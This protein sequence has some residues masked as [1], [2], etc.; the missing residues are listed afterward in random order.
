[1][2]EY[3]PGVCN[4]GKNE[5]KKRYALAVVAFIISALV[6]YSV[7]L[8]NWPRLTLFISFIPLVMCFEGFYQGYFKFC[9][10]FAAAGKYDFTGSGNSKNKV[11]D[12]ESHKKDL[13]KAKQIHLYSIITAAIISIIIYLV[14]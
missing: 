9:A 11:A 5:I 1:M 13:R 8:L 10:G 3:K 7:L 2:P 4:I 6:A 14:L 12:Q